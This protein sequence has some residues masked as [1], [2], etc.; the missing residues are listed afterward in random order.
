MESNIIVINTRRLSF[1]DIR[2]RNIRRREAIQLKHNIRNC[3]YY[4]VTIVR[5]SILS[6]GLN[7]KLILWQNIIESSVET[8]SYWKNCF[9]RNTHQ[10]DHLRFV[11]S[12]QFKNYHTNFKLLKLLKLKFYLFQLRHSVNCF[13]LSITI[14]IRER[15]ENW[16]N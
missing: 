8:F 5:K 1:R 10:I 9:F 15:K 3:R 2:S 12:K 6:S 14:F 13:D 4:S 16:H 11:L 7:G